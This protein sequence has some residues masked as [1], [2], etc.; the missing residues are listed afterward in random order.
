MSK[1]NFG[2]WD[3]SI[4][5]NYEQQNRINDAKDNNF[6]ITH[7]D[8]ISKT[9]KITEG[10]NEFEVTLDSCTCSD[11]EERQLPCKHIY[12]LA[13]ELN[14]FNDNDSGK[15]SC[16]DNIDLVNNKFLTKKNILIYSGIV[17]ITFILTFSITH[18]YYSSKYDKLVSKYTDIVNKKNSVDKELK[19]LKAKYK[20]TTVA[21][22]EATTQ[23]TTAETTT[24]EVTTQAQPTSYPEGMYKVGVDIPAGEYVAYPTSNKYKGYFCISSDANQDNIITNDNFGGQRYFSISEG[25]YL[26]LNRCEAYKQ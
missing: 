11:F 18:S 21:T 20:S 1:F 8:H 12:K 13:M 15:I 2:K 22:T 26:E 6:H 19:E 17:L 9:G 5:S 7:L 14:E 25:Q 24:T 23:S 3:S 4:H 16:N 10:E